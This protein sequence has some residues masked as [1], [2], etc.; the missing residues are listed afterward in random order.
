[1]I[2]SRILALAA[3]AVLSIGAGC[4]HS[5]GSSSSSEPASA[6]VVLTVSPSTA[7]IGTTLT[8][9]GMEFEAQTGLGSIFI[10]DTEAPVIAQNPS[11]IVCIV[12]RGAVLGTDLIT[13]TT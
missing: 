9:T 7:P 2:R 13:V 4:N 1:M 11:E 6:P 8:V 5:K 3:C 12:P 10:G